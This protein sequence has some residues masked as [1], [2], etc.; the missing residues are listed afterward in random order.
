M[1]RV[2]LDFRDRMAF[3]RS[4]VNI[5][6]LFW[7]FSHGHVSKKKKIVER[8]GKLIVSSFFEIRKGLILLL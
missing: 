1:A 8:L 4:I 5:R 3:L 6:V 2:S 7:R